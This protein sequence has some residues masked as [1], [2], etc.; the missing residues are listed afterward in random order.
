MGDGALA[1]EI[2]LGQNK[3]P[4]TGIDENRAEDFAVLGPII[5]CNKD[6]RFIWRGNDADLR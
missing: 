3:L 5:I 6:I 4:V 2:L 1:S